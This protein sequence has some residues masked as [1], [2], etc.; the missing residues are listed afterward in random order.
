MGG[1]AVRPVA[2][3]V[4]RR[5]FSN[6]AAWAIAAAQRRPDLI[7]AVAAFSVGVVPQRISG[8]AR[9]AGLRHYLA[10]GTL[11]ARLPAVH[12][13]V[14]GAAE[15]GRARMPSRGMDRRS[16]PG[17]G[18]SSSFRRAGL[19]APGLGATIMAPMSGPRR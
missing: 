14:G 19:A 17:S 7:G 16:R 4:G 12:R 15:E 5:G 6:G 18:G 8:A 13:A 9:S 10:A 2:T 3:A 1:R 11:E